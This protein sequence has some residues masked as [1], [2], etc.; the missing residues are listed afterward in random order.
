MRCWAVS[1]VRYL[2]PKSSTT[3][4]KHVPLEVYLMKRHKVEVC[5]Y[6]DGRQGAK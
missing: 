5:R 6:I 2:M 3:R 1:F 4:M